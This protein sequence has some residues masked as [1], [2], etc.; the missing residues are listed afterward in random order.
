MG[1]SVINKLLKI[2]E[3]VL[4]I[5]IDEKLFMRGNLIQRFSI[6]SLI[7]LQMIAEIERKFNFVIE[8]D[9]LAIKLIDSPTFFAK[10]FHLH[11]LKKIYERV[12]NTQIEEKEIYDGNLIEKKNIDD[13]NIL[14]LFMEIEEYFQI[15]F[16]NTMN[17]EDIVNSPLVFLD[18]CKEERIK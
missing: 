14:V 6:D 13:S 3:N 12:L 5:Q 18:I 4:D 10:Y 9:K 11:T 15:K 2:Y 17:M 8:E 7:A 16:G 1:K